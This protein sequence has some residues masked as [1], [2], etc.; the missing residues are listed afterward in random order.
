MQTRLF[1][2]GGRKFY[3][4][5]W[6][7]EQQLSMGLATFVGNAHQTETAGTYV[8]SLANKMDELLLLNTKN[9]DL[10][11]SAALCFR[12][13]AWL[14]F[15][16]IRVDLTELSG[17]TRGGGICFYVN[18]GWCTDVTVLKKSCS[19]HLETLF[20]NCKPFYSL[21]EFSLF[22]LVGVYIH[23]QACVTE[24]LQQ[25]ADQ[26]RNVEQQHP[27][28]LLIVL[29]DCNRANLSHQ[30]PNYRQHIKCPTNEDTNI[31]DHCYTTLKN[32]YRSVP[33]AALGLSNHCLV[34]L[35]P[36]YRQKLKSAKPV[37]KTVRR[38]STE[39]KLELQA[40]FD[41][42]DWTVFDAATTDLHELTDTVTSYISFCEEIQLR[43][44][45]EEAYRS[46]DRILYQTRNTLT[47]EIR[48]AK[49]SYT[50]KLPADPSPALRISEEDVCWLFQRQ[51]IR[52]APGPDRSLELCEVPSCFKCSTIIPIPKKPS[53]TGL[54]D[55]RPVAL[56]SV[57]MKSFERLVLD[58]TGPLLDPLQFA[59]RANRSVDDAVNMGLHYILQHLD[60]PGTYARILFV[61]FSSAFNTIIPDI[62]HSKLSQLTVPA[63]TC[64]VDL[65]LP[66]RQEAADDTVITT[67]IGLIRDGDESA[68]RWEVEQ[69]VLW[70]GQNNLEMNTLKTVEM[71]AD[72]RRSPPT[73]PRVSILNNTESA[74]ETFR[75]MGSTI[76]EDLKWE[77][78]ID[79]IRKKAQQR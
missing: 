55:Y 63:P 33:Q 37:A 24:T 29:G 48:V 62:F 47:K 44:A 17:K 11:R 78:N 54:S 19:P 2:Y 34:H 45:K 35:I 39:A 41:C 30:L 69:L 21:Q 28:S 32:A 1:N 16:L 8:R 43:Q 64:Q 15:H 5:F 53:I 25:L 77:S 79:A 31:L 6:S 74:V 40:C 72:F 14:G 75:F 59:Y 18:K 68:Y 50:E 36:T 52:K 65:K 57:V 7:E 27:D 61:D 73:L 26:I 70:C 60:S 67:V 10:C 46:G 76:S 9:R 58:I 71:T 3:G 20:I 49:R 4:E 42:T 56:T 13:L 12:D 51:K 22:I 23:P 38:W 66:D